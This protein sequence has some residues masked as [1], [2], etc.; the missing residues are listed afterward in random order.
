MDISRFYLD[1]VIM[2]KTRVVIGFILMW[3]MIGMSVSAASYTDLSGDEWFYEDLTTLMGQGIIAGY[4]DGTFRP[5]NPMYVDGFIKM[6]VTLMGENP[7]NGQVYWA[8][9]YIDK[10][11]ELGIISEEDF[12]QYTRPITRME[13]ARIIAEVIRSTEEVP[14]YSYYIYEI[15][16]Y[17]EMSERDQDDVALAMATGILTGYEDGTFRGD[18]AMT[19]AQG[20]VVIGRI[21]DEAKRQSIHIFEDKIAAAKEKIVSMEGEAKDGFEIMGE[22]LSALT[23]NTV[24][25]TGSETTDQ[26][27]N[28]M[29]GYLDDYTESLVD[30][31]SKG[32]IENGQSYDSG[33]V[34]WRVYENDDLIWAEGALDS[35]ALQ[36]VFDS[37]VTELQMEDIQTGN[38][39]EFERHTEDYRY[40]FECYQA[41][42]GK[43]V[44]YSVSLEEGSKYMILKNKNYEG[45]V[46]SY[47][48]YKSS[49]T[50]Y[51]DEVDDY[52]YK[53]KDDSRYEIEIPSVF[54][55]EIYVYNNGVQIYADMDGEELT[56]SGYRLDPDGLYY[57][58]Q[59][60]NG[61]FHGAGAMFLNSGIVIEDEFDGYY[62]M[63]TSTVI[64]GPDMGRNYLS[65]YIDDVLAEIIEEGMD[66]TAKIKAVHDYLVK[67]ITYADETIEDG[68]ADMDYNNGY[69]AIIEG[70]SVCFGYAQG[71]NLFMD[72]LGIESYIVIGD[73]DSDGVDDHAWNYINFGVD[74]YHVDVTWDDPDKGTK[75][76]HD[77]FMKSDRYMSSQR[78]ISQIMGYDA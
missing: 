48:Q 12:E 58:G 34:S 54:G 28:I 22:M 61:R 16:D 64:T 40:Y 75:V 76:S 62:P 1:V 27:I 21:M 60:V 49:M 52:I 33:G 14:P 67:T 17:T 37:S 44:G 45:D 2:G 18:E 19:R 77:Y 70:S 43:R 11:L 59:F 47:V 42:V 3:L 57:I 51:V 65:E 56:G 5:D 13:S 9:P 23:G 72:A 38:T 53:Y 74:Y 26:I 55:N 32:V 25:L 29:N 20:M 69:T 15:E 36:V 8:Q 7:G 31:V 30:V 39:Y 24:I 6:A 73:V 78:T 68:L 71:M 10:A 46:L 63:G 35:Y 41:S 4:E 66:R 50:A